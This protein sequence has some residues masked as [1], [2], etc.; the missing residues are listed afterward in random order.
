MC[1]TVNFLK[2][3]AK[4]IHGF[5]LDGYGFGTRTVQR[6]EK[7]YGPYWHGSGRV[8]PFPKPPK[9]GESVMPP[10]NDYRIG[11]RHAEWFKEM[12]RVN[13]IRES[14]QNEIS[15]LRGRLD[16]MIPRIQDHINTL[17]KLQGG[18]ELSKHDIA[19]LKAWGFEDC[20]TEDVSGIKP[21]KLQDFKF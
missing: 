7:V 19:I 21:Y 17:W 13:E 14:K 6:G 4:K 12:L 16:G 3:M 8:N 10:S 18:E 15:E 2:S 9:E 20:T 5:R 1:P 11:K